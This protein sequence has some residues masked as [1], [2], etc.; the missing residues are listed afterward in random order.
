MLVE[1]RK[2]NQWHEFKSWKKLFV[3]HFAVILLEM[4][5]CIC[6]LAPSGVGK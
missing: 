6:Y 4:Y 3:I 1:V 5:E 2:W